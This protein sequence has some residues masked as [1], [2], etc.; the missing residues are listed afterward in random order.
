V[1][2]VHPPVV[3]AFLPEPAPTPEPKAA[4]PMPTPVPVAEPTPS[5]APSPEPAPSPTP[6]SSPM[7]TPIPA[8]TAETIAVLAGRL[9][10]RVEAVRAI[11]IYGPG[12][13]I[14]EQARVLPA[15]DGAWKTP[16]PPPGTY[17]VVPVGEG[18]RPLR[19]E[20]HFH[21]VEVKGEARTDLDFKILG[22][23]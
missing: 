7:T 16:L 8:P 1:V 21:T 3:Q 17:R 19:C 11:V 9:T 5:P 20:P 12:S 13:I 18:S 14:R 2:I 23:N 6:V 15:S 4:E 10:G 22:T